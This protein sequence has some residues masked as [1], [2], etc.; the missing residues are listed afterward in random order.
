MAKIDVLYHK[1]SRNIL[2]HGY[3]YFTDNREV[4]YKQ[5]TD[6]HLDVPLEEEFPLLTTKKMF[7][8]GIVE[9]L[10]WFLRGNG[11]IKLLVDKGVTIW[12]KDTYAYYLK[13]CKLYAEGKT[14]DDFAT[15]LEKIANSS[16][17]KQ[18]GDAGRNYGVQWRNWRSWAWESVDLA[19]PEATFPVLR[20]TD[21][22]TN[23]LDNLRKSN[24]INRRHIV[25][26]WNPAEIE[27]TALPPCHWAF[28]ILPK[29]LLLH[30]KIDYAVINRGADKE[31]LEALRDAQLMK[32]DEE[33]KK[34]LALE[35]EGIP[36]YGFILKW[37][38][39]SVDTFLGLPFNIASYALL[40][41][42]I[43]S[44]TDM[45]PMSIIG[46]LSNVHFY[47]PHIPKIEE[48]LNNSPIA[49]SGCH[50]KFSEKYWASLESYKSGN[51]NFDDFINSLSAEDF[52]F[53]N[54]QSFPEIKA[55]M[56]EP[57]K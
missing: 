16:E 20:N 9:E 36:D 22:I 2:E 8:R 44:I 57:T 40:A 41:H 17:T 27:D 14:P 51:T 26:A 12:N 5:L 18:S 30:H 56:Y 49:F 4:G 37:H 35:L 11:N 48:Q 54:Y 29:P 32:K 46:D 21:Q 50:L 13:C 43:G 7:T 28:E 24:P 52:I 23:L 42:I 3:E 10:L 15:W 33:A 19:I 6:M 34:T 55:E 45:I 31:Y 1:I 25:T 47:K 38:Q 53:D 39:R